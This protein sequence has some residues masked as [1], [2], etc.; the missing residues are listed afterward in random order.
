MN[1]SSGFKRVRL[2]L[3]GS[4]ADPVTGV[5]G[6]KCLNVTLSTNPW[7]TAYGGVRPIADIKLPNQV[8]GFTTQVVVHINADDVSFDDGEINAGPQFAFQDVADA[9]QVDP[10]DINLKWNIIKV[11]KSLSGIPIYEFSYIG[12]S[13]RYIGTM[14]QD[15]LRMGRADA[16]SVMDNGYYAVDYNK[17]DIEFGEIN[18]Y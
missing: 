15:L 9:A 16:V 8:S 5:Y 10:S 17:I 7:S 13:V 12:E 18:G 2:V 14:A 4:K 6:E 3:D 1:N 11:G